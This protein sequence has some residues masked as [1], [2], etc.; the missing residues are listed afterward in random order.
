MEVILSIQH[1][2]ATNRMEVAKER[3]A[4]EILA[5]LDILDTGGSRMNG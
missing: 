5:L 2:E 4:L 1:K 3:V